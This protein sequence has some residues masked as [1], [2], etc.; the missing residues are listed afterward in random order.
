[1]ISVCP[2]RGISPYGKDDHT[3]CNTG[4]ALPILEWVGRVFPPRSQSSSALEDILR[5]SLGALRVTAEPVC[6]LPT[7]SSSKL[8]NRLCALWMMKYNRI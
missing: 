4:D 1:M 5:E 2:I 6:R 7:A 3:L 8:I